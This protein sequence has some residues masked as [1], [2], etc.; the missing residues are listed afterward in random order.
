MLAVVKD[1]KGPGYTL[2]EV[3]IPRIGPDDVLIKVKAVGICGTDV[4]ILK[5]LREV[6]L[7][8][9]PGHEFSGDIVEVGEGVKDFSIGQRVT[10][11]IV[12][13]CGSCYFCRTGHE[14]LCD[15]ILE[16]GIHVDGA[17]AEYVR[18]PAKVLHLLPEAMSYEDA[19]A[20]DPIASAYHPIK[21]VC[22]G[23]EDVVVVY[24]VG[25]IGLYTIQ[26]LKA[27]GAKSI[28]AIDLRDAGSRL[29]LAK[30][31]GADHVIVADEMDVEK[32]IAHLTEGRGV[33]KLFDCTG[34]HHIFPL[35]IEIV[36][37]LGQI[38]L[39]GITHGLSQVD[40]ARIV[41]KEIDIKGSICYTWQDYKECMDLLVSGRI[42][43]R[44]I[45]THAFA[46]G[47]ID[48]AMEAIDKKESIKTI[49]YP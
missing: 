48:R 28:I 31:L 6:P 23:S 24:G 45:V 25:P 27:E 9:I 15:N 35:M 44:G 18:V 8:L 36:R 42:T 2:K 20:I 13:G 34:S 38:I 1:K 33:D 12:I 21:K 14:S 49:L 29:E 10:P 16:T 11:A 3:E 19:A 26:L 30:T 4:P 17:F 40:T 32:E 7:P 39:V 46:L 5:G 22:V 41:R 47:E 37:K 43:T